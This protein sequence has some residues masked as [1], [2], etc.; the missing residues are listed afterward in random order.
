MPLVKNVNTKQLHKCEPFNIAIN[1]K[2]S[3]SFAFKPW[4]H[5]MPIAKLVHFLI[6]NQ[7]SIFFKLV[8]FCFETAIY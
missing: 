4:L 1:G 2:A 5:G 6:C 3:A 8:L 7:M